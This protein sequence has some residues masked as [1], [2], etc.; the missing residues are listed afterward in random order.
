MIFEARSG[1]A[2]ADWFL[3]TKTQVGGTM[4]DFGVNPDE[5]HLLP[6]KKTQLPM[7]IK[8][9][10]SLPF[11]MG[12]MKQ[13]VGQL[14]QGQ[15][16]LAAMNAH[17]ATSL[18]GVAYDTNPEFATR[19]LRTARRLIAMAVLGQ[20]E[21]IPE[22]SI[23]NRAQSANASM[24]EAVRAVAGFGH[25]VEPPEE[26]AH[27][28]RRELLDRA[29]WWRDRASLLRNKKDPSMDELFLAWDFNSHAIELARQVLR[30]SIASVKAELSR[31]GG[32]K[33]Y[34]I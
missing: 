34:P 4:S 13:A 8:E 16:L 17:Y 21:M 5:S 30:Q 3:P 19:I 27:R 33:G 1:A 18:A 22:Q 15:F 26:D 12:V 23:V 10:A 29:E 31:E 24:K 28:A 14:R 20:T 11:A 25:S 6:A 32:D 2:M 7:F 9:Y